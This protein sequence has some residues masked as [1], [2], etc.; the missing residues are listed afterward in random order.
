MGELLR[1]NCRGFAKSLRP[2][3]L[4]E[5][6]FPDCVDRMIADAERELDEDKVWTASKAR[7]NFRR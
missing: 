6:Y 1:R 7:S 5:G 4:S 3:L 2:L